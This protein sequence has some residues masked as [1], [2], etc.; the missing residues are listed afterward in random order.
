MIKLV[1]LDIYKSE[2]LNKLDPNQDIYLHWE[3]IEYFWFLPGRNQLFI[4]IDLV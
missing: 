4:Q 2:N 3:S 1:Y